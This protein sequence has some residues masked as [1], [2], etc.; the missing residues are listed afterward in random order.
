MRTRQYWQQIW[1]LARK[2]LLLEFRT[3][4]AISVMLMYSL[5]IIVVFAF[6]FKPSRKTTLAIFPGLLWLGSFFAGFL[7]LVRTFQGEKENDCLLGLLLAPVGRTAIYFGKVLANFILMV[8]VELLVLPL[9]FVFFNYHLRGPVLH[10]L[11][12]V[13]LGI[14]GFVAVETFLLAL[15]GNLRAGEALLPLLL[16]PLVVPVVIAAV[17]LTAGILA[18][19]PA[20]LSDWWKLLVAYD[21]IFLAVPLIFFD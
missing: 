5:V 13:L 6:A 7:G 4:E 2:D 15:L 8:L 21:I 16:F 3:R 10:L 19:E 18:G 17:Q 11:A 14:F 12:A 1:A 20:G 9:F